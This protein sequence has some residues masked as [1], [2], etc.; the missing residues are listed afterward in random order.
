V[1]IFATLSEGESNFLQSWEAEKHRLNL[2][3]SSHVPRG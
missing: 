2:D 3:T 1:K